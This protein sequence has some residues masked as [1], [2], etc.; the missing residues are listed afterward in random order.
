M[1][2]PRS[3]PKGG[4]K[5]GITFHLITAGLFFSSSSLSLPERRCGPKQLYPDIWGRVPC[6]LPGPSL[7]VRHPWWLPL[8]LAPGR[9]NTGFEGQTWAH[10]GRPPSPEAPCSH[11]PEED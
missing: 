9:P 7:P 8:P 6:C 10:T 4:G 5:S 11:L 1:G 3:S 2:L